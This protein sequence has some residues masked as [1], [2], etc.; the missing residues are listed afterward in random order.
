MVNDKSESFNKGLK[1]TL[2]YVI[3]VDASDMFGLLI[4]TYKSGC[5]NT[6]IMISDSCWENLGRNILVQNFVNF[7]FFLNFPLTIGIDLLINK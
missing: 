7:N 5:F 2:V 4:I 1:S 6:M 3:F